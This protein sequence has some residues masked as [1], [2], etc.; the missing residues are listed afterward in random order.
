M[1]AHM[2]RSWLLEKK[3]VK[4]SEGH[5]SISY[6]NVYLALSES[7]AVARAPPGHS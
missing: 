5:Q 7:L 1:C 2:Y 4:L 6:S 3:E